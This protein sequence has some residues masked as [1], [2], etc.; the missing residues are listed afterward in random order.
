MDVPIDETVENMNIYFTS[1]IINNF[2][3]LRLTIK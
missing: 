3:N 1:F 2:E